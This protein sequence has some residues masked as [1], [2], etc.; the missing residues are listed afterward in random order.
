M[1]AFPTSSAN[2]QLLIITDG[3]DGIPAKTVTI[4]LAPY[5]SGSGD[6]SPENVRP[7]SGYQSVKVI[8]AGKSI[9]PNNLVDGTIT[10][11]TYTKNA[12][13]SVHVS[14]TSENQANG[15][16]MEKNIKLPN[17][18][19]IISGGTADIGV[20]A[21]IY[22]ADGTTVV[23]RVTN[24]GEDLPFVIDDTIDHF[25]FGVG[26]VTTGATVDTDIYPMI[27]SASFTDDTYEPYTA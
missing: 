1:S 4:N 12:D 11:I 13:G 16:P 23:Q 24:Y 18:T 7:I 9:V 14:G 20:R 22:G 25:G 19:Y 3:A 10:G 2:G 6:P 17:G 8:R 26:Y 27:R 21:T 15:R 5:Q